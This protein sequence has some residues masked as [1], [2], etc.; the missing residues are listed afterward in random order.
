MKTVYQLI[1]EERERQNIFEGKKFAR[2]IVKQIFGSDDCIQF[3]N[4]SNIKKDG[5]WVE[6]DYVVKIVKLDL[7]AKEQIHHIKTYGRIVE[8]EEILS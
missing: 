8:F 2:I 5:G 1:Q 4:V 3:F 6:F 7:S